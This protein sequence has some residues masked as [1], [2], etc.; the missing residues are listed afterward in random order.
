MSIGWEGQEEL[1]SLKRRSTSSGESFYDDDHQKTTDAIE[2]D[3]C[4]LDDDSIYNHVQSQLTPPHGYEDCLSSEW[5]ENGDSIS[6]SSPPTTTSISRSPSDSS[7]EKALPPT[8]VDLD[9]TRW[10]RVKERRGSGVMG[11]SEEDDLK[12]LEFGKIQMRPR[13][14]EV[15]TLGEALALEARV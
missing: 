12:E 5:S 3:K 4:S 15:L 8:P 9:A 6:L 2:D 1:H 13:K 7:Q 11:G 14:R 10:P